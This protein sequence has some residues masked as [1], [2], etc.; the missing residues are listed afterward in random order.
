MPSSTQW[1]AIIELGGGFEPSDLIAY[2]QEAG[3]PVPPVQAKLVA[4]GANV[5]G[6]DP[7]GADPEVALDVQNVAGATGGKVGVILYFCPNTSAGLT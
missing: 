5:P 7:Q 4:G 1:V 3:I 6:G 2:C